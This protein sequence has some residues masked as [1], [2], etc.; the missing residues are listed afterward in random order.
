MGGELTASLDSLVE[1]HRALG[2][3]VPDYLRP[4]RD[5]AETRAAIEG[6]GLDPPDELVELF[7]WHDGLDADRWPR[8]P[9]RAGYP[10]LWGDVF[11]GTL[12]KTIEARETYLRIDRVARETELGAYGK[13]GDDTWHPG[14]FPVF[15]GGTETFAVDCRRSPTRGSAFEVTWHPGPFGDPPLGRFKS[16]T[17]MVQA[18]VRRFDAGAYTWN[19]EIRW[20]DEDEEL[21]NRL[22]AAE[23]NEAG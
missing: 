17:A 20:L 18:I 10:R 9:G 7:A 22:I 8:G 21:L 16:L 19:P 1:R 5:P 23:V 14:W 15:S 13:A 4:G 2:S 11:F 6:L 12:D 3:T